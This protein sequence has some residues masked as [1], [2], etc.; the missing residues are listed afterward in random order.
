MGWRFLLKVMVFNKTFLKR[1]K[2][3]NEKIFAPT[4]IKI[5]IIFWYST[6]MEGSSMMGATTK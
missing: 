6:S 3:P 2:G 5:K 4:K 1:K